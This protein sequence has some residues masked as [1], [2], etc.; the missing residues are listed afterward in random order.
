MAVQEVVERLRTDLRVESDDESESAPLIVQLI[1]LLSLLTKGKCARLQ[2][3]CTRES[4]RLLRVAIPRLTLRKSLLRTL[5]PLAELQQLLPLAAKDATVTE[6]R[7]LIRDSALI[8]QELG[9]W[10]KE[11]AEDDL[12]EL[13]ASYVSQLPLNGL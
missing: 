12:H 6:G 3:L 5:A 10:V 13:T 4:L 2:L 1:R 7:S 11:K 8:V 9:L